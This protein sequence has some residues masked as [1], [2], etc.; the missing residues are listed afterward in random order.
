MFCYCFN[1]I[2]RQS[3]YLPPQFQRKTGFCYHPCPSVCLSHFY[4][5]LNSVFI[6]I[7]E[8]KCIKWKRSLD[9][10]H[11]LWIF[12]PKFDHCGPLF[13]KIKI[14]SMS[15]WRP[16]WRCF[17]DNISK[18]LQEGHQTDLCSCV[19]CKNKLHVCKI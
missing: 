4:C 5:D 11:K 9:H 13:L 2:K 19:I 17:V 8:I 15:V 1:S 10:K 3:S 6:Y 12:S 16:S 14:I 18:N 7:L